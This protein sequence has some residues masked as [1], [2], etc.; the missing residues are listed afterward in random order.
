MTKLYIIRHA[1]AEGNIYRRV[2]GHYQG[3]VTENG[4]RQIDALAKRFENEHIDVVYSSDLFR[5]QKTAGAI[6]ETH[7]NVPYFVSEELREMYFGEFEGIPWGEFALN[8][9]A[10]YNAWTNEPHLFSSKNGETYAEVYLRVKSFLDKIVLDNPNKTVA[11]VSHGSAIRVLLCGILYNGDITRLSEIGWCDNTAVSCIEADE[12]LNYNV[13]FK[14]DNSHLN[15]LST[16]KRQSWWRSGENQLLYN[17]WYS[18]AS[19][20]KD[21]EL[22]CDYHKKAYITIFGEGPFSRT[23][24]KIHVES[25]YST[26]DGAIAFAHRE[27]ETIGAVMLDADAFLVPDGGHIS[28]IFLDEGYRGLSY[29]IQLLGYAV[30]VYRAMGRKFLTVRV[31]E[32]NAH[33]IAF[34]KKYGFIEFARESDSGTKQILM[35][36]P[37]YFEL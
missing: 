31:A 14:N 37:I 2:Q 30:S 27:N 9:P 20:P 11:V 25:L 21:L 26:C 22:A 3:Y 18:K 7:A 28:L 23:A 32:H 29:G 17:L 24:S 19:F 10:Q 35:K 36:K 6:L 1:E 15:E 4:Y 13:L 5:T 16:L 34:Y 33:A 8:Y 12:N